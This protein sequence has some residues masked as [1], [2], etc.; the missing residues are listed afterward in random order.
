MVRATTI[1][2]SL[3]FFAG[4]R[5]PAIWYSPYFGTCA[6]ATAPAPLDGSE[7]DVATHSLL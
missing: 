1:G 5:R 2:V 7:V 3:E 6:A 4:G